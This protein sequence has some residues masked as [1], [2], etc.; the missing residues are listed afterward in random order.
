MILS[1]RTYK[2]RRKEYFD[3][4]RLVQALGIALVLG[5]L[6]WKSSINTEAGLRDQVIS[7]A[8]FIS[9]CNIKL[10]ITTFVAGWFSILHLYILDIFMHF[11]SSLCLSI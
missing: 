7:M 11:C 2:A 8:L 1:R 10:L 6:W 4:L 9:C 3:K 5:L